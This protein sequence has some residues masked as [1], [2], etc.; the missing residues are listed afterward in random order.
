MRRT[1]TAVLILLVA[2]GCSNSGSAL[3]LDGTS[4]PADVADLLTAGQEVQPEVRS[5]VEVAAPVDVLE[6]NF[7]EVAPLDVGSL[8]QPGEGC[9]LDPCLENS[10]CQSGWCVLHMGQSVCTEACQEECPAGWACKQVAGT[11]PDIVYVC[12]SGVANMC[13]PCAGGADC[14]SPNGVSDACIM[15]PGEGSFCGGG[16]VD[17]ECPLGFAC[18]DVSTVDGVILAQCVPKNGTCPCTETSVALG[19]WTP[20]KEANEFGGC[21]GKRVCTLD[22]LSACDAMLP[23]KEVCN[24]ADDDCDGDVDEPDLVGGDFVHLCEDS[25]GCTEDSCLGGD[26]CVNG[27]LDEGECVD[28]NPCTVADHCESGICV[29][30][31]VDCDDDNPCTDDSCGEAGGCDYEA[32]SVDC[33][34]GDP[35]TV[36]DECGDGVCAGTEVACECM[37][38]GDC[39]SLEDGD[40]CNGTLV[41]D[42]SSLPH[43]C[44]VDLTTTVSCPAP[45]GVAAICKQAVCDPLTGQCG[46]APDHE[47][48]LCE[49]G[50]PCTINDKC[51]DGDCMAGVAAN[52]S[53][54]NPCTDD[55]CEA[56][57][58][59][60]HDFNSKSC[61]DGNGC[62]LG[63]VCAD[64]VCT[65]GVGLVCD[66]VNPCTDDGCDPDSGCTHL[67]N[68][69]ACSDGNA[70]TANDICADGFCAPGGGVFCDDDNPC[71]SDW[72]DPLSGCVHKLNDSPCSDGDV[73]TLDD[74]C[75]LG[76]CI[77]SAALVCDDGNSCTDDACDGATGCQFVPNSLDCDDGNA[78]TTGD[79]CSNGQCKALT[80][81]PCSDD[82]P[83]T[84]D[85]CDPNNGCFYT[86][87][88]APC[89]DGT[90]CTT[91]DLCSDGVCE[92]GPPLECDDNNG[93][94][95][96]S[97]D[98]QFGCSHVDNDAGCS[99]GDV[100][101]IDDQCQ[102]GSCVSG[103][104]DGCDDGEVC[105][106]DSCHPLNGCQHADNSLVCEDGDH[107]TAGDLCSGGSCLPGA[108]VN[109]D[110]GHG[111][112]ADGCDPQS[113][114]TH[115]PDDDECD[116]GDICTSDACSLDDG[117]LNTTVADCCGNGIVEAGEACDDGNHVSG[118]GC[119]SSCQQET[120]N[121]SSGGAK[122]SVAPA[123][124]MMICK[125]PNYNTCEKDL[126]KFCP[127]GWHLCSQQEFNGRNDGWNHTSTTAH[128][129]L[130]VIQC[131]NG[132]GAGHYTVPDAGHNNWNMGQ[133]EQHNC[134]FGSSRAEC[135]TGYGCN[136]K[137]GE[138]LC[139]APGPTCGN[140]KVDSPE[141]ACDDGNQSNSDS[142]L[143]NCTLRTPGGGGTNC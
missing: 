10:D 93:C 28:G 135:T 6:L 97:C 141:E 137:H 56:G 35:C 111:C 36:A 24:G 104:A 109:C 115:Q 23:A 110:D 87:N 131:R 46:F 77:S 52:C 40:L 75:H 50:D 7:E 105:T 139:C 126:E 64:G 43:L 72:C 138:A 114:C 68:A 143:N 15:L 89:T 73:C 108:P 53:D 102:N 118:D 34:D 132:G 99:D 54:A 113:G 129:A 67:P 116:D 103:P 8:C 117:C 25:N 95:D 98:F 57:L 48:L 5:P 63:D 45:E 128:R 4:G 85:N 38:D 92:S 61:D 27:A 121:C 9:F 106:D 69:V 22:G 12:V 94:T 80:L 3:L 16:C 100:C 62:T 55:S 41:C 32:N 112:T 30:Q 26:G 58:G 20:C 107:C 51:V 122:V 140:G 90:V 42:T 21:S 49:D 123:G 31:P 44:K 65:A 84:D 70:C 1:L 88:S 19:L 136:E 133:D 78:C 134:Y 47:A 60:A 33:D 124:T 119:S 142:C 2:G 82:N 127:G 18:E 39:A 130:G 71:T 79:Q 59:C 11:D 29:G 96:D 13:K 76:D 17:G 14:Q 66:D 81:L 86:D 101:T 37:S 91:N 83:C 120:Y 125:D 74:H